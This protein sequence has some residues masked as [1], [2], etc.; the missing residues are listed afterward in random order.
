MRD[1]KEKEHYEK[2]MFKE[3]EVFSNSVSKQE[4]KISNLELDV[5]K[6][7]IEQETNFPKPSALKEV[8]SSRSS[9]EVRA[10]IEKKQR[11]VEIRRKVKA[12]K[13]EMKLTEKG[14]EAYV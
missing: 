10:R 11:K 6:I 7:E 3:F 9:K 2:S 8:W 4:E 14:F 1:I 13:K 5:E 12:L